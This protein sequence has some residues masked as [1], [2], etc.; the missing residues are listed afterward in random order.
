MRIIAGG[1]DW[2]EETTLPMEL[3]NNFLKYNI[4]MHCVWVAFTSTQNLWHHFLFVIINW[5]PYTN[6]A[7]I[8]NWVGDK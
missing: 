1:G 3:L 2:V 8:Y 7:A 6:K 4:D 5:I